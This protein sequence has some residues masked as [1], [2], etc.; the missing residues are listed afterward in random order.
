MWLPMRDDLSFPLLLPHGMLLDD[1]VVLLSTPRGQ[2]ATLALGCGWAVEPRNIEV[3]A[4]AVCLQTAR[5]LEGG[6]L[7]LPEGAAVQ[8]L[9]L[10][11]PAC[12]VPGWTALRGAVDHPLLTVQ[13]QALAQGLLHPDAAAP[14]G[15]L[16]EVLT[17]VTLRLPVEDLPSS[18][19]QRLTSLTTLTDQAAQRLHSALQA[20]LAT[21]LS[22]LAGVRAT[23]EDAFSA[24]GL[25]ARRQPGAALHADLARALMPWATTLPVFDPTQPLKTQV[26]TTPATQVAGGWH[27]GP[28]TARVLSLRSAPPQTFPGLLSAA[29]APFGVRPL[30]LWDVWPQVPLAL[31]VN[32]TVPHRETELARLRQKRALAFLQRGTFLGDT[33]PEHAVLKEE[34]DAVLREAFTA[35]HHLLWARVHLVA[36]GEASAEARQEALIQAGRRSGLEFVPEP[37]LGSTLFLQTLPLGFD[38]T[39]PQERFVRR[40]RR[41]PSPNLAQLLPLYGGLRGTPTPAVLYLSRQGE[42][43]PFDHFD[44]PT[45]P[46]MVVFGASG[47]GKS[48]AINHLVQQVLPLGA[49]VVI[50]D[51]WASY[52]TLCAVTGGRYVALDFDTPVCFNPFVGPLD[53]GHRAFLVAVLAEM[54]SGGSAAAPVSREERAVL[55]E[56]LAVFAEGWDRQQEPQLGAFVEQVLRDP[57]FDDARLGKRLARKLSPFVGQGP[58]AGFVDGKNAFALD[59]ALTVVEL[60][61]LRASPDLQAVLML[62]LMHLLTLFFSDPARRQQRKYLVSDEAWALLQQEGSARVLEEIARTF[63]KLGTCAL[64]LSQQGSDFASPAG[65]AIRD[66]AGAALFLQ[67]HPE[68]VEHMRTVFD[69]SD[70][71]VAVLKTVRKR[72]RWS[73]AYLRLTDHTGGVV[74]IVPDP[75]LRWLATQHPAERAAREAAVQVAGGDLHQALLALAARHPDGLAEEPADA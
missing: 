25:P 35:G 37:V 75:Y 70:Q 46:H 54:A 9:Q 20:G 8:V 55:A 39:Y 47:S 2:G 48:F 65:K 64:F 30:A 50:L 27:L 38:P 53:R 68:E 42:A 72:T 21:T 34:L 71:E 60:A 3:C 58:Y 45:A 23:L 31:V 4:E 18:L 17:R 6:L 36:W 24:A 10:M 15:R 12:E 19:T 43:V 14:H 32:L 52:D 1:A 51:R 13:H 57:P 40:A 62:I 33:S 67:Q 74:R 7:G 73:E 66:N 61:R 16:R 29:R 41:L 69:L 26:L 59:R 44:L 56:A 63:R 22:R 5:A 28:L 11:R 49:A